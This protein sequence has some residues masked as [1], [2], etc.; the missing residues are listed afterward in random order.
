MII[1]AFTFD[2]ILVIVS[3]RVPFSLV[4]FKTSG[5]NGTWRIMP[6]SKWLI[7]MV[8][9][10]PLRMGLGD[11]FLNG[12]FMA[13]KWGILTTYIHWEPILQVGP[14]HRAVKAVYT[15]RGPSGFW[16][17]RESSGWEG[18]RNRGD[19]AGLWS[20]LYV[21]ICIYIYMYEYIYIY[22]YL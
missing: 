11:P 19:T 22:T 3:C 20:I 4:F 17:W 2:G 8:I 7:T 18:W 15:W 1:S 6:V 16:G 14:G 10:S 5:L 21:C 9:V 13:Y 12:L